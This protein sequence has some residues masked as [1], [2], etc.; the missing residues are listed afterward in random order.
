MCSDHYWQVLKLDDSDSELRYFVHYIGWNSR[1]D[2]W[3]GPE[4][5]VGLANDTAAR[6]GRAQR[7]LAKVVNGSHYCCFMLL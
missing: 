3:I 2:E 4:V 7:S 5:V 1:Y 6:P